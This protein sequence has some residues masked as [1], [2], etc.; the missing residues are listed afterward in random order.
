MTKQLSTQNQ[1]FPILLGFLL[2][3]QQQNYGKKK[4]E[5]KDT[6]QRAG[7]IVAI[8]TENSSRVCFSIPHYFFFV[9]IVE[10]SIIATPPIKLLRKN[11]Q[12]SFRSIVSAYFLSATNHKKLLHQI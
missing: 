10:L 12:N 1:L 6:N 5:K 7:A 3:S 4:G 11:A 9:L 2:L 8:C